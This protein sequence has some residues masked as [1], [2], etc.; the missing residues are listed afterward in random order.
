MAVFFLDAV[1]YIGLLF[2]MLY[3]LTFLGIIVLRPVVKLLRF[4]GRSR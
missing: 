3:I 4:A 1:V 2:S